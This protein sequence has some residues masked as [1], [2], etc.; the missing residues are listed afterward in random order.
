MILARVRFW[1][2]ASGAAGLLTLA[3]LGL[4][5]S[6]GSSGFESFSLLKLLVL[7]VAIGALLIPV[8]VAANAKADLPIVWEL[9]TSMAAVLALAALLLRLLFSPDEGLAVGYY[10]VLAG[11]VVVCVA[12]WRSVARES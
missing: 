4:E 11:T 9:F 6:D 8:V 12:G 3:G 7:A 2:W 1:E 10:V 5:W